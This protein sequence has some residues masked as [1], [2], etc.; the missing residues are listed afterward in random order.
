MPAAPATDM[1]HRSRA[2]NIAGAC[3]WNF[4]RGAESCRVRRRIWHL[5]A[6]RSVVFARD[7]GLSAKAGSGGGW[8]SVSGVG[9]FRSWRAGPGARSLPLRAERLSPFPEK[10]HPG[11]RCRRRPPV[12]APLCAAQARPARRSGMKPRDRSDAPPFPPCR[13]RET[14]FRRPLG[15]RPT[16]FLHPKHRPR[17]A[18]T[19]CGVSAAG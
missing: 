12:P 9:S 17:L 16:S 5:S 10:R 18:A 11:G 14:I 1:R 6:P 4:G 7:L 13:R 2:K 15:R 8:P 3:A 19:P